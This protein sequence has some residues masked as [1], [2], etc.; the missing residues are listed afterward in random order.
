MF[1]GFATG[2][3]RMLLGPRAPIAYLSGAA[4]PPHRR[5]KQLGTHTGNSRIWRDYIKSGTK[6]CMGSDHTP[7]CTDT[8]TLLVMRRLGEWGNAGRETTGTGR[9][10]NAA[11]SIVASGATL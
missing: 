1:G 6:M 5:G 4:L 11:T 3:D 7:K 8:T 10:T 2:V 9:D